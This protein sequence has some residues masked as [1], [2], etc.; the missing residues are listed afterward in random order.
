MPN[1]LQHVDGR[2]LPNGAAYC[3]GTHDRC[4]TN[5]NMDCANYDSI[6]GPK[7]IVADIM[8]AYITA[9]QK[10]KYGHYLVPSFVKTEAIRQ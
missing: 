9:P 8:N 10:R 2:L 5:H 7:V 4:A 3:R 6:K 1:D